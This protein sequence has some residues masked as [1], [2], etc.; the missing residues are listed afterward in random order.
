MGGI[1]PRFDRRKRIPN[2]I[3]MHAPIADLDLMMPP[4]AL[5]ESQTGEPHL[6]KI[7]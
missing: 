3:R 2:A 1:Q 6:I 5:V 4:N 7:G